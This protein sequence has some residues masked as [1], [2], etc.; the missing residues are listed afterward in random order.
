[1]RKGVLSGAGDALSAG[2]LQ[3]K[4][5][6][7]LSAQAV[8]ALQCL[9]YEQH[10]A[11][12]KDVTPLHPFYFAIP[13]TDG[14]SSGTLGQFQAFGSLVSWCVSICRGPR[15]L[16]AGGPTPRT[17]GD[18]QG[19]CVD[20]GPDG[21]YAP[22]PVLGQAVTTALEGVGMSAPLSDACLPRD[23]AAGHGLAPC[24]CLAFAALTA[25][26]HAGWVWRGPSFANDGDSVEEDDGADAAAD[27]A[28]AGDGIAEDGPM[29]AG[30]DSEEEQVLFSE[31]KAGRGD[32]D[33]LGGSA[34]R[35]M[36]SGVPAAEWNREVERAKGSMAS[37]LKALGLSNIAAA[38]EA[39][40]GSW[41]GHMAATMRHYRKLTGGVTGGV[42]PPLAS[43]GA[44]ERTAGAAEEA[45]ARVRAAETRM[46]AEA[47]G[48][49]GLVGEHWTLSAAASAAGERVASLGA[50]VGALAEA[51]AA[52]AEEAADMAEA[53][54]ARGDSVSDASPLQRIRT[55]L[56]ALRK[57]NQGLHLRLGIALQRWEGANARR[58]E[59][60]RNHARRSSLARGGDG[61]DSDL[62][63]LSDNDDGYSV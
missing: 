57:E 32:A 59:E 60:R 49:G 8:G 18:A 6:L 53:V 27:V 2:L 20:W 15:G 63:V 51:V 22:P 19:E 7:E 21:M 52:T 13:H 37:R 12:V 55:A 26:A 16:L 41:R 10:W 5:A 29:E 25:L 3:S 54:A 14:A 44:L 33:E 39:G 56:A 48:G 45:A 50:A 47:G 62:E 43:L 31:G 23:V 36:R 17:L 1:V 24:R 28:A 58:A 61:G 9:G 30:S 35:I 42:R 38:A 34:R 40:G 4:D 46:N 11:E